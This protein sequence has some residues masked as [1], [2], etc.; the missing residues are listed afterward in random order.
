MMQVIKTDGIF[1][2]HFKSHAPNKEQ[3][4]TAAYIFLLESKTLFLYDINACLLQL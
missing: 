3:E 2:H 4:Q 1:L